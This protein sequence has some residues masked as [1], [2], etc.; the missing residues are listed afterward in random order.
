MFFPAPSTVFE[1]VFES[2]AESIAASV[3]ESFAENIAESVAQM[4][5]IADMT[6]PRKVRAT[7]T[8]FDLFNLRPDFRI[9]SLQNQFDTFYELV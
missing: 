5:F 6:W 9:R 1:S 3:A 2:V 4:I 8:C 7:K